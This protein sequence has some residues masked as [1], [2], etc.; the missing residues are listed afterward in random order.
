MP[1]YKSVLLRLDIRPAGRLSRC[2]SNKSHEIKKG[3]AGY[4]EGSWSRHTRTGYCATCAANMIE[5]AHD[6]LDELRQ[7]L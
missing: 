5:R 4:R 1:T 2:R 3:E 7:R 6:E